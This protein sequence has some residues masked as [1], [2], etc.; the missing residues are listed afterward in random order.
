MN[1]IQL[2]DK[3]VNSFYEEDILK[4]IDPS[5][6]V[7]EFLQLKI[8]EFISK[9]SYA[10]KFILVWWSAL[11]MIYNSDRLFEDLDFNTIWLTPDDF[12]IVC[13]DIENLLK[14]NWH[15][16]Y[17]KINFNKFYHCYFYITSE[18]FIDWEYVDIANIIEM[19][20][21]MDA[22]DDKWNYPTTFIRPTKNIENSYILTTYPDVLLSKKI[23]AFLSRLHNNS[24]AK[25]LYDIIFLFPFCDPYF[26]ILEDYENIVSYNQLYERLLKRIIEKESDIERNLW[27]LNKHLYY[28]NRINSVWELKEQLRKIF[29][30]KYH[31]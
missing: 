9:Q 21:K 1:E 16:T 15:D 19:E 30:E 6:I 29:N 4:W 13:N 7:R 12:N 28:S 10:N 25:D 31:I 11:R 2:F 22:A 18:V 27:K 14:L 20:I 8:L 3:F 17:V 24:I 5:D 23:V 26:Q